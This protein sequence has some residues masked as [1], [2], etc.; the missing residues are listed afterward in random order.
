MLIERTRMSQSS[1]ICVTTLS[2]AG[3]VSKEMQ[4]QEWLPHVHLNTDVAPTGRTGWNLFTLLW[5]MV[6]QEY[7]FALMQMATAAST[8]EKLKQKT[9]ARTMCTTS[10][11]QRGAPT[12]TVAAIKQQS[13]LARDTYQFNSLVLE[14]LLR[15]LHMLLLY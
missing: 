10:I 14:R 5:P 4:A 12:G 7:S 11:H 8:G 2:T 13:S 9:V 3:I 6:K 1:H 15:R